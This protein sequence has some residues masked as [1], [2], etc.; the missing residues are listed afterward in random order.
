MGETEDD[1]LMMLCELAALETP[2]ESVPINCL[3]P[4]SGTPL[5]MAPAVDSLEIVRLVATA[6][7]AF[8]P[9]AGPTQCWTRSDE[10]G[11][12]G[13][14]LPRRGRLGLLRRETSSPPPIPGRATTRPS[15]GRWAFPLGDGTSRWP[16]HEPVRS[17]VG[18]AGTNSGAQGRYRSFRLPTGIDFT[19]N[20]Y[21]GYGSTARPWPTSP[22]SFSGK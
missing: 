9:V 17:L 6:R 1:R 8:S 4:Q 11:T 5:A 2:P 7:I 10:S 18:C 21:L 14:V 19:S 12:P 22:P 3:M 20:D 13:A 16:S 15:S